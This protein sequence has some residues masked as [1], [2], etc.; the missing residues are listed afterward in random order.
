MGMILK[1]WLLPLG[2][3]VVGFFAGGSKSV[4]EAVSTTTGTVAS[5][6]STAL[7]TLAIL[8]L[9]IIA[10]VLYYFLKPLQRVKR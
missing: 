9:M 5:V 1:R 8:F 7:A 10:A 2:T 4:S 6:F 3:A